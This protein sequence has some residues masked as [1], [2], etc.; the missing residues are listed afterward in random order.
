[1]HHDFRTHAAVTEGPRTAHKRRLLS[2]LNRVEGQ[3]RGI[4]R[5]VEEDQYCVDILV[6]VAAARSALN[7]VGLLLLEDHTRGCVARATK[8]GKE[9]EDAAIAELMEV[10]RRYVK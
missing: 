9:Q 2:R 8:A 6:Q 3:I 7:Q 1:M 4:A 5:M 10:L